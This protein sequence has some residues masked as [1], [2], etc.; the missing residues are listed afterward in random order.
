MAYTPSR[1]GQINGAGDALALFLKVFS[2]EVLTAFEQT[3][4]MLDKHMIRTIQNGKSATFPATGRASAAYF[5]PGTTELSGSTINGNEVVVTIDGLLL[6]HTFVHQID[7]L[8]NHFD[9]RGIYS[10]ELGRKLAW[11]FD[12]N[13]LA[14]I[15]LGA[16]AVATVTGLPGGTVI[17]DSDFGSATPAT[18]AQAIADALFSA[19]QKLD[20]NDAPTERY[21]VFRPAEYYTLVSAVQTGGFSVIHKDYGG[22]GSYADGKVINIAGINIVKS[23]NLPITNLSSLGSTDPQYFHKPNASTTKG[24]VFAREAVATVKLMDLA[25]ESEWDIRRQGT[26]LVAKYAMGHKFIRPE[27]CVELRTGAPV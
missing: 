26:W 14:E 10:T 27:C 25:T 3:T 20:E 19:A 2:G 5:V 16:R 9:V 15:I 4:V 18:K 13:V 11:A 6:A 12:T 23:N 7:E 8:M 17:E 21:A 1:P 22:Q 24:V